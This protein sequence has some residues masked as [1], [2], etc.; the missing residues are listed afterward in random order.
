[1]D[2]IDKLWDDLL[3]RDSEL[4]QRAYLQFGKDEQKEI[5]DHLKNMA[6]KP[7]WHLE[8]KISAQAALKVIDALEN[9]SK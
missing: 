4:I 3:S 5:L 2:S 1:M 7:G 6:S 9:G 8:Q